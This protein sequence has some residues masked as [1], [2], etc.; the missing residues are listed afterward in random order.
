MCIYAYMYAYRY[1]SIY[2]YEYDHTEVLPDVHAGRHVVFFGEVFVGVLV[3][4]RI[5]HGGVYRHL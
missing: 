4:V 1:T 5:E 2:T 3:L